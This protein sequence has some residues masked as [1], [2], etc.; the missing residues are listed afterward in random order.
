MG[1]VVH[2][3]LVP[4]SCLLVPGFWPVY[5]EAEFEANIRRTVSV[6]IR[7]SGLRLNRKVGFDGKM[8]KLRDIRKYI[9]ENIRCLM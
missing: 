7:C 5:V 9:L 3:L 1:I 2:R 4:V 6:I 8:W